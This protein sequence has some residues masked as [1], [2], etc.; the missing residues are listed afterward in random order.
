MQLRP[1][2]GTKLEHNIGLLIREF[3]GVTPEEVIE[4]VE[5]VAGALLADAHFD[6]YVP[7][8]AHR[9]ARERLRQSRERKPSR[10]AFNASGIG[11]ST[12]TRTNA[13]N[14]SSKR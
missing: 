3:E 9:F 12:A 8:L 6:D 4:E 11:S 7:L 5:F 13:R 14:F 1:A 10:R 2:T